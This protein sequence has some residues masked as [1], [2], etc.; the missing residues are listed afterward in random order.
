MR[1]KLS[2]IQWHSQIK[3]MSVAQRPIRPEGPVRQQSPCYRPSV[4][5]VAASSQGGLNHYRRTRTSR[6]LIWMNSSTL[7][8]AIASLS[9]VH[10][11]VDAHSLP[12]SLPPNF[13]DSDSPTDSVLAALIAV[14]TTGFRSCTVSN[15]LIR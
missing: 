5:G 12:I 2:S 7:H 13:F 10:V 11:L 3:L 4:G 1:A 6:V 8:F 15:F 9:F 14:E